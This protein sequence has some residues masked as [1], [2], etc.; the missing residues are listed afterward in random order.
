MPGRRSVEGESVSGPVTVDRVV[1]VKSWAIEVVASL[2]VDASAAVDWGLVASMGKTGEEVAFGET[3][4][5]K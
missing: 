4:N 1:F 5:V 2:R 3:T